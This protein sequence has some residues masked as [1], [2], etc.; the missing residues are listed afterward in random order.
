MSKEK[1]MTPAELSE[2]QICVKSLVQISWEIR[3]EN[4]PVLVHLRSP[5]QDHS[6]LSPERIFYE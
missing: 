5:I 4:G 1:Y 6:F 2:V 3:K